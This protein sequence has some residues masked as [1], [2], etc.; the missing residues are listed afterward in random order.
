M[1]HEISEAAR[2]DLDEIWD[3]LHSHF[4]DVSARKILG[5]I[6]QAFLVLGRFPLAGRTRD[7]DLGKGLRSFAAG[8]HIVIYRAGPMGP[9]ILRMIHGSRDMD[10]IFSNDV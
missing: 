3:F 7:H 8:D 1:A 6:E 9:T 5:E 4:N 2:Q 10:R